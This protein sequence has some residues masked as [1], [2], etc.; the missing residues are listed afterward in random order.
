MA[1]RIPIIPIFLP[2]LGC[3]HRCVFCNIKSA[4]G[5][6]NVI[7]PDGLKNLLTKVCKKHDTKIEVAL[8]GGT[9][10]A[11]PEKDIKAYLSAVAD[12]CGD[13]LSH[14]RISTRPD[15]INGR[16][17]GILK[18]SRVK[19]IEIGV[20]SFDDRVLEIINRGHT[21]ED[22]FKAVKMAKGAGFTTGVQLMFGL[23]GE[24]S[25]SFKETVKKTIRL[26]PHMVRIHPT[27]VLKGS[28]LEKW[29][30]EGRFKPLEVNRAVEWGLFAYKK[31]RNAG[32]TVH[33]IGLSSGP[34]IDTSVVAGPYKPAF[35]EMVL[36]GYMR[37]K[38][39]EI[40]SAEVESSI[41]KVRVPSPLLSQY[42]GYKKENIRYFYN[43]YGINVIISADNELSGDEVVFEL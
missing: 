8:Y 30:R 23:P 26:K 4:F 17:L 5:A 22:S 21:A 43:K 6:E 10:T 29:Y 9:F 38:L 33:R 7:K 24:T 1:N 13:K 40:L 19:I 12:G 37:D 18:D 35:G 34:T 41:V 39:E 3:P 11:L 36:S 20:Q 16:V 28:E 15:Y 2:H 32:I 31:F 25:T 14:I 42:I 27:I